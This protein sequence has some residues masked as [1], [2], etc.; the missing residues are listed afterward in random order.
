MKRGGRCSSLLDPYPLMRREEAGWLMRK[1]GLT[2]VY[3]ESNTSKPKPGHNIYPYLLR[4][5]NGLCR[6]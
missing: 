3:G 6:P 5:D 2:P 4:G 1:M